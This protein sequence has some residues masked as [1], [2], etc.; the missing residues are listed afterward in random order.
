MILGAGWC[1]EAVVLNYVHTRSVLGVS[2]RVGREVSRWS[3]HVGCKGLCPGGMSSWI[4]RVLPLE[5]DP[6]KF[7]AICNGIM[8]SRIACIVFGACG[9][10]RNVFYGTFIGEY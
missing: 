8:S 6:R 2:L 3:V 7:D 9:M 1:P 4:R 10:R 5:K